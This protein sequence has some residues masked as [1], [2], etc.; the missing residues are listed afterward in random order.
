MQKKYLTVSVPSLLTAFVVSVSACSESTEPPPPADT[1]APV[2]VVPASDATTADLG[3]ASWRLTLA[4][5][6]LGGALVGVDASGERRVAITVRDE[7]HGGDAH[8]TTILVE[9]PQRFTLRLDT[10]GTTTDRAMEG[11]GVRAASVMVHAGEDMKA[12]AGAPPP[13]AGLLT[14]S[15][16]VSTSSS[17]SGWL[18]TRENPIVGPPQCLLDKTNHSCAGATLVTL[19]SGVATAAVCATAETGV[20]IAACVGVATAL[21]GSVVQMVEVRCAVKN[22]SLMKTD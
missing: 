19:G 17:S 21:L 11:D 5:D 7:T 13:Q 10:H 4:D 12:H 9:T 15:L 14:S 16:H 20:T 1:P 6:A 22:C 3:V 8:V 2:F 18:V